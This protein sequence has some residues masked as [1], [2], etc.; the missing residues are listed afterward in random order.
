MGVLR[1]S[2]APAP[3]A[4]TRS[5]QASTAPAAAA[6]VSGVYEAES[7]KVWISARLVRVSDNGTEA[8][9][10]VTVPASAFSESDLKELASPKAPSEP[11]SILPATTTMQTLREWEEAFWDLHNSAG[12]KTELK[13]DKAQYQD[14][15][16]VHLEFRT[17]KDC[18]LTLVNIGPT[19]NWTMLV[20]NEHRPNPRH[21]LVRA[22]DG[23][24]PVPGPQDGFEFTVSGPKGNERIKAICTTQPIKLIENTNFKDGFIQLSPEAGTRDIKVTA[25]LAKPL[26]W[27]ETRTGVVTLPAGQTE[28][29]GLRGLRSKGM[30]GSAR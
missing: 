2:A 29:R 17:T 15:E 9:A 23:W 24:V 21:A 25:T 12:F 14:E 6:V 3:Q 20:P 8:Q 13:T 7:D 26:E 22:S 18:Y 1:V 30:G 5:T 11:A 19:G 4:G 10:E 27:S 16:T 28:T